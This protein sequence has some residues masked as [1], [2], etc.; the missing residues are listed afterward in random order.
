MS[1]QSIL[2][3][4]IN[5]TVSQTVNIMEGSSIFSFDIGIE[6]PDPSTGGGSNLIF[7]GPT[8]F[9]YIGFNR[10]NFI[11]QNGAT[12]PVTVTELIDDLF[13]WN[14]TVDLSRFEGEDVELTFLLQ[15]DDDPNATGTTTYLLDNLEF[16]QNPGSVDVVPLPAPILFLIS[17]MLSIGWIKRKRA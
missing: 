3:I 13:D 12:T 6:N 1:V 2:S 8:G 16:L 7:G 14:V 9:N 4:P 15:E 10:N 11:L 17:G 5:V